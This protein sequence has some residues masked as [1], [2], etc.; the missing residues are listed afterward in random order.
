MIGLTIIVFA[1]IAIVSIISLIGIFGLLLKEKILKQ[2]LLLTVSFSAGAILGDV[3][4]HL[5]PKI[6]ESNGFKTQTAFTV[7]FG[8]F[9]FFFV[10]KMIKWHHCH[11][12]EGNCKEIHS[13]TYM[14][15]LGDA[16]HNFVDGLVIAASFIASIPIGIA[17]TI[18]VALHE[19]PQEIGDFGILI[20][21]GFSKIKAIKLNFATS[22]TSFFGGI[23]GLWFLQ[24][25]ENF[26]PIILAF[27]VGSFIY[28]AGSD[29]IPELHKETRLKTSILQLITFVLGIAIMAL[30]LLIE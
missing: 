7:L 20:H 24:F 3:F 14:N 15:L 17:T 12:I 2:F 26:E 21:G 11:N 5:I 27:T 1:S 28:I 29:L 6:I 23:T 4:I 30:L 25:F 22:L 9:F 8:I 16:I 18:A 13:F 10:E 19:I